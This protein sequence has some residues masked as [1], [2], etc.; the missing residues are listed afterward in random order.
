[1]SACFSQLHAARAWS[2]VELDALHSSVQQDRIAPHENAE[3][4]R[5][6]QAQPLDTGLAARFVGAVRRTWPVR[7]LP[8]AEHA[9]N[10]VGSGG[11]ARTFNISTSAAFVAAAAG[12]RVLKSGSR[13]YHGASGSLDVLQVLGVFM[14]SSAE[15]LSEMLEDCSVAF[16]STPHYAPVLGHMAR[17]L[18]LHSFREVG[19][20]LNRVGP[21]LCP[22]EV[23]AQ[24]IGASSRA[25]LPSSRASCF[26]W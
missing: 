21:L 20:F 26:R 7:A 6:L 25:L 17:R 1:M 19:G 5:A 15:G 9:V 8:G 3:E 4:L 12:A 13:S 16:V 18:G 2:T 14:P 23:R 24:L 22:Y 10:I 11:G